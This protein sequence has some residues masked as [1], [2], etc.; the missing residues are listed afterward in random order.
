MTKHPCSGIILAGGQNSRFN[1]QNKACI[2]IGGQRML[3]RLLS[4]LKPLFDEIILV[5]ND[6]MLYLEWDVMMVT[7][8]FARRSSLTGIHAGLFAAS[9]PHALVTACDMPFVQAPLVEL[10]L[11]TIE[12][13]WDVIIPKTSEGFEPLL[14][15]YSKRC[16][17]PI[18]AGLAQ[19]QY[20]VQAFFKHIRQKNIELSELRR[21]D[22][23]LIS[24]FNV[25]SREEL[26]WAED[27]L[28]RHQPEDSQR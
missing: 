10:L 11:E 26:A 18:A 3:D 5:T 25:N 8:H 27:W 7:D 22:D 20:K 6:P 2:E 9:N 24:F 14:A 17:K 13:Q 4:V 12:P 21:C 1:R 15:V 16:L 23:E 19:H 28:R